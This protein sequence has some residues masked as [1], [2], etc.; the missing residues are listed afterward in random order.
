MPDPVIVEPEVERPN[1]GYNEGD[2]RSK[3]EEFAQ[4]LL[5]AIQGLF[6]GIEEL[7]TQ[8]CS[9]NKGK[10]IQGEFQLGEGYGTSQ[11]HTALGPNVPLIPSTPPRSTIPAF[12]AS[13]AG[14]LQGQEEMPMGHY[15]V[16]YQLYS[17]NFREA[18]T[19]RDF[20]LLKGNN[21]S[22]G[23]GGGYTH[24]TELQRTMGRL[25]LLIFDGS[26]KSSARAWVEKLFVYFQLNQV[27]KGDA[28]KI[29][30]LHI[31]GEAHDWWFHGLT[32]MGHA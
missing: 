26:S 7:R 13:G 28:I 24:G 30:T 16:E 6:K 32:M 17:P 31:E 10:G 14:G 19:F 3:E 11:H 29:A 21:R 9:N 25:F 18:I 27:T 8:T 2:K 5:K 1:M 12:L 15:F 4:H 22:K 20:S 23:Q